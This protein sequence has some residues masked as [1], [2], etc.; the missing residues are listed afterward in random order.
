MS[1]FTFTHD[2]SVGRYFI[3]WVANVKLHQVHHAQLITIDPLDVSTL[4]ESSVNSHGKLA[5]AKRSLSHLFVEIFART[6]KVKMPI[7]EWSP[8]DRRPPRSVSCRPYTSLDPPSMKTCTQT[9]SGVTSRPSA[10]GEGGH[11]LL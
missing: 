11:I 2:V 3:L 4:I 7:I 10:A 1:H 6:P 8:G 9:T 5:T